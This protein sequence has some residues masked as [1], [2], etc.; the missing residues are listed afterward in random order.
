[1]T[2]GLWSLIQAPW[3]LRPDTLVG[4]TLLAV[5]AA[6]LGEAFWRVLRWPRLLGYGIVGTVLALT[7]AGARGNET[8][9]RLAID[10]ALALLLFEAGARLNLRWLGRNPWLLASSVAEAL[11]SAF[12]VYA[13]A[14]AFEVDA[15]AAGALAVLTM[16]VSPA[17]VQRVVSE[18]GAAGQVTER[19]FALSALNTL[20]AVF[21]MQLLIAG[22]RLTDPA[23]W[24]E[25]LGPTVFSFFGSIL[26]G[27]AL[28]SV[29]A[30]IARRLDLRNENSVVLLLG[31]V[32]L[33]LVIAKTLQFSTLLVPLL[34]G[35][36]LRNRSERPWVWPR[37]FGTAGGVL[38]LVLFVAVSS[39]WSVDV[40]LAARRA[41]PS[42]CSPRASPPRAPAVVVFARPSGL[43]WRQAGC[44]AGRVAAAVRHG[45]GARAR[46]HG[47][48]S[49]ARLDTAA[50]PP[51]HGG[52]DGAALGPWPC[53]TACT[54]PASSTWWRRGHPNDARDLRSL[55][56]LHAGRRARAADRQLARLR[57]HARRGRP[58]APDEGLPARGRREARD[59]RAA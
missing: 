1:M 7:G 54:W 55:A 48:A 39:A 51:R 26:L 21:A 8:E 57:P 9:L 40:L 3:T 19:L 30:A 15:R 5:A 38:V 13:V 23:T 53:C 18:C 56:R 41:R 35:L 10:V 4:A 37:H 31:C 22:L 16:C 14:R 28:G 58:A 12:A 24:T 29:V 42:R 27:A 2:D 34:A 20:Y 50:D 46:L 45:L 47:D 25:A 59:H 33:A 43:S 49:V 52:V 17:V 36:W 32:L 6:L 44:L 11:L